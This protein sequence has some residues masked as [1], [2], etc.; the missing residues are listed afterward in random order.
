MTEKDLLKLKEEIDEAKEKFLQL[1][2]QRD[3]LLQQLKENWGCNSIKEGNKLLE[4]M[5]KEVESL[6]AEIVEGID[7]L[8][9]NYLKNGFN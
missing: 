9:E 5:K 3:A 7:K 6:N 8:E 4:D 2:G 1:K